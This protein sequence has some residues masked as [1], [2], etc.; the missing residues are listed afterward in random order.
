MFFPPSAVGNKIVTFYGSIQP[1][2]TGYTSQLYIYV[3][4]SDDLQICKKPT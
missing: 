1:L 4:Q 3:A 2:C